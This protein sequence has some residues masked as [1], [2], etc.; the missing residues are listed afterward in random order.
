MEP[1]AYQLHIWNESELVS[2]TV[3]VGHYLG[4]YRFSDGVLLAT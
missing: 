2:H 3:Y 4:P 1:P